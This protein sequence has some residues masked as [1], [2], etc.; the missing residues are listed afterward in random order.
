VT[1]NDPTNSS[2]ELQAATVASQTATGSAVNASRWLWYSRNDFI[3]LREISLA[4][5]LPASWVTRSRAQSAT[6]ILS[7]RN[8]STL[9]TM[10]PGVDPEEN[11]AGNPPV[12]K[13]WYVRLNV[14]F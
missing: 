9:W 4:A 7:G 13:Q 3:K 8:L 6:L 11:G 10:W 12:M 5:D 1:V 2:L 14:A